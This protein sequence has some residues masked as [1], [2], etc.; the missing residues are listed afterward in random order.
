MSST[1]E[2]GTAG[3]EG[4]RTLT[5]LAISELVKGELR[6]DGSVSVSSVAPLDRAEK[7]QVSFLGNAKYS[8]VAGVTRA[9][10]VL[11]SADLAEFVERVPVRVIVEK[12]SEAVLVLLPFLYP[13][14]PRASFIHPTA[15]IGRGARI[16]KDVV[17]DEYAVIG[18]GA[19]VGDNVWIGS[20]VV[21]GDGVKVGAH[22]HLF[23]H[24]C[25]Y[26]GAEIGERAILHAGVRIGS[27]GFGYL[28]RNGA[29]EKVPHVGRCIIG[30]DVEIGAN[31]TIDRGSVDDTVIGAGTKI[32]NL[33]HIGHN[34]RI[35]RM[36]LIMAQVGIAGSVRIGDGCIIAG[37]AGLG[38]HI[39][40][41]NGARI[42]GQAGV[43]GDVPAGES[44]SGY[45]A[46][47]HKE[48]LRATGALFKLAGMLKQIERLLDEKEKA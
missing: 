20:H 6:G 32:D 35:G 44:W 21:V 43:F 1:T 7:S 22:S 39:T 24:V 10:I 36:C 34:C 9:G 13:E 8:S 31:T 37:Q 46:R 23:P 25:L 47:P 40:I 4:V 45:P 30:S 38:G 17:V 42:A 29:H 12:P 41:G 16:G 3:G 15:I 2:N 48:S 11:V 28:Q 14:T 26:S 5:A 33:V 19:E 27:D 18:D